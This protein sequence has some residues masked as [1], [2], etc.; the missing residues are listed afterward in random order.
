MKHLQREAGR[1]PWIQMPVDKEL[2]SQDKQTYWHDSE[3]QI[4]KQPSTGLKSWNAQLQP[5]AGPVLMI[6]GFLAELF[7]QVV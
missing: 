6:G 7:S 4:Q 1:E 2:I 3:W 5:T